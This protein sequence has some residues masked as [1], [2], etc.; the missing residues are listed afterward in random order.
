MSR[1]IEVISPW[2]YRIN[3]FLSQENFTLFMENI[4]K[5]QLLSQKTPGQF[6]FWLWV[7]PSKNAQGSKDLFASI[8]QEAFKVVQLLFESSLH[9][10]LSLNERVY[11]FELKQGQS[12]SLHN[13][14]HSY[15]Q[16][17]FHSRTTTK[18]DGGALEF[19]QEGKVYLSITPRCNTAIIFDGNCMHSVSLNNSPLPRNSI[20]FWYNLEEFAAAQEEML[21]IK[22]TRY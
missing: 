11:V 6:N 20:G 15:L 17:V 12:V 5:V 22:Q 9:K 2:I 10:K 4:P 18:E 13:D 1:S 16:G 3:N 19:T 21:S 7:Y 14:N 8:F